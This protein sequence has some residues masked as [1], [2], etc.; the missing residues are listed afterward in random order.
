LEERE[1]I[2]KMWTSY[3]SYLLF[4]PIRQF[5]L[6]IMQLAKSYYIRKG[7]NYLYPAISYDG[8]VGK[9]SWKQDFKATKETKAGEEDGFFK[10]EFEVPTS[11]NNEYAVDVVIVGS[12]CG[13]A[14]AAKTLAEAGFSVLVVEKGRWVPTDQLPLHE[15]VAGENMYEG[16]MACTTE[17]GGIALLA[18]STFG[19]GGAVNWS[20]SL[21]TPHYVRKEWHEKHNL[22]FFLSADYQRC[23]DAVCNRMGVTLPSAHNHRNETLLK[24]ARE[25]GMAAAAVPQNA[26]TGHKD[27]FCTNG[28]GCAPGSRK[29]GTTH[30][31]L[32]DAARAGAKFMTAFHCDR[33]VLSG[34]RAVGVEGVYT[35]TNTPVT[36]KARQVIVSGGTLNSPALLLRSKIKNSAIGKNLHIHPV[37][38]V[39]AFYPESVKPMEGALLTSIV[40]DFVNLDMEYHG[41]RLETPSMTPGLAY[42]CLPWTGGEK[43]KNLILEF[44]KMDTYICLVR[45]KNPG[46]IIIDERGRPVIQ[47]EVQADERRW[48]MVGIEALCNMAYLRGAKT[49]YSPVSGFP[50]YVRPDVVDEKA[51]IMEPTYRAWLEKLKRLGLPRVGTGW[52]SAHHMGSCHMNG[53]GE[54]V[55]DEEGRVLG[56]EALAIADASL[57]PSASGVNPMVTTMAISLKVAEGIRDRMKAHLSRD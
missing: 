43:F 30:T 47:Y 44:E 7:E 34:K 6:S 13:G 16:G 54:G 32:P 9:N 23:L 19:G 33:V 31:W 14:V 50:E 5:G 56:Y 29:N 17:D 2:L 53:N 15:D 42:S 28:C 26:G 25:M 38:F 4:P 48:M 27:G 20:A 1:R 18:G 52:A 3:E 21:Q 12:G 10:F 51:G 41:C 22:P 37:S 35:P 24:S 45:E 49:I 39:Q 46:R 11:E 40:S 55:C 8:G 36:I 57:M